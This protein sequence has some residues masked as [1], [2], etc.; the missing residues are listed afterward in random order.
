MVSN[1]PLYASRCDR[2]VILNEGQVEEE[3]NF[4]QITKSKH[5]NALF[6]KDAG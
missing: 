6:L 4:E 1:D 5:F 3:G 2:I